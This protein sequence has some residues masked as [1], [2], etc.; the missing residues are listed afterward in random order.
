MSRWINISRRGKRLSRKRRLGG[1][2][3]DRGGEFGVAA[4][5]FGGFSHVRRLQHFLLGIRAHLAAERG[6][7]NRLRTEFD[8][9]QAESAADN[10]TVAERP[11]DLV[12]LCGRADVEIFGTPA[13]EQV[14]YTATNEVG[15]MSQLLETIKNLQRVGVDIAPAQGMLGPWKDDGKHHRCESIANANRISDA[16]RRMELKIGQRVASF[17]RLGPR[18]A[19]SP[20]RA[21]WRSW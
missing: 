11:L 2:L 12:R 1:G 21:V 4:V 19:T 13:Q 17:G 6:H 20:R 8:V 10:P 9:G 16:M 5:A 7:F 3:A 15:G 18:R 14:A